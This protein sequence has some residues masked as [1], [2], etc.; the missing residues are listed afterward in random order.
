VKPVFK[1][2]DRAVHL[3]DPLHDNRKQI[4]MT[5]E[6]TVAAGHLRRILRGRG[7]SLGSTGDGGW[8]DCMFR[9]FPACGVEVYLPVSGLHATSEKD[10]E[11]NLGAGFFA[12]TVQGRKAYRDQM[13]LAPPI[14]FSEVPLTVFSETLGDLEA[15]KHN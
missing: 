4:L 8:M 15:L 3:P 6:M 9:K 5:D 14:P 7:W 11:V 2:M 13:D 1:P 12:R 10:D